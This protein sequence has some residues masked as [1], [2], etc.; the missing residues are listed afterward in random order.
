MNDQ[1]HL[2]DCPHR[3]LAVGWALHALEPAEESLVAAHM[4]ECPTCTSTAAQTEEVSATLGLSVPEAIPSAELEQRILSV[5]GTRWAAPVMPPTPST[6]LAR[7]ITKPSWLRTG[8]LAAAVILVVAALVL[9]VRVVQLNGQLNQAQHQVTDMTEAIQSA[10]DPA[11]VRVPLFAKDGRAVVGMVLASRNRVAVVATR[12]PSN[13][14]E[15]QTY[16]L[17]GLTGGVPV[18]LAA[19]DV[20]S[21]APRLHAVPAATGTGRFTGYAVSL[22]PGRRTPAVPTDVVATSR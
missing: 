4:P 17:W 16:V 13:R 19:F 8:E 21:Q 22:E 5:T 2:A 18:A 10:E 15:D 9:G 6:P 11:A 14:A 3:E 7:H 20:A 12:L 1:Q